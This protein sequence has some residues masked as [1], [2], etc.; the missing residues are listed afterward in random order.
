MKSRDEILEILARKLPEPRGR[1]RIGAVD[2]FGSVSR[3][4]Q[5]E[6]SDVDLAVEYTGPMS[7]REHMALEAELAAALGAKVD[8]VDRD[9][10]K[11]RIRA[12]FLAEAIRV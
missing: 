1:Y 12:R 2:L 6:A 5:G 3:N 4:E 9:V 8:L 11:P 7:Y 10:L